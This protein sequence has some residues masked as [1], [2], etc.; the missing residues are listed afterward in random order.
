[1]E[2]VYQPFGTEVKKFCL[3]L[4]K[5]VNVADGTVEGIPDFAVRQQFLRK[6]IEVL[7]VLGAD[8]VIGVLPNFA[9]NLQSFQTTSDHFSTKKFGKI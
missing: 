1:M 6:F 7:A 8:V 9:K 3:Q 4:G 2:L 5:F